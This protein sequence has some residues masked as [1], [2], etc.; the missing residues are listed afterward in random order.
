MKRYRQKHFA[1]GWLASFLV[2]L[3][4]LSGITMPVAAQTK[5]IRNDAKQVV[6]AKS[7]YGKGHRS[8]GITKETGGSTGST[9]SA[10]KSTTYPESYNL[11]DMGMVT[12]V[13][14]QGDYGT[15]WAFAATAAMESN[16]LMQGLGEYDLSE[17]QLAY[18]EFNN[19]SV[20]A[21]GLEGDNVTLETG[22]WYEVG[23]NNVLTA[24]LLAKGYGPVSEQDVPY[25]R[26]TSKLSD[27]YA[28]SSNALDLD[29]V[30]EIASNNKNAIKEAIM[31]NGAVTMSAYMEKDREYYNSATASLYVGRRE[32]ADH[33]V[34][35]VGWDDNYSRENF[36]RVKPSSNGAWLCKNSWGSSWGK[37]GY[38][39][40]SYEDVVSNSKS[41]SCYSFVMK[42][43]GTYSNLYQYDG[44]GSIA[45]YSGDGAANIF[46]ARDKEKITAIRVMNYY[47]NE[48][49]T[50]TI[51][52]GVEDGKPES[53]T[54]VLTQKVTFGQSGYETIELK[55]PVVVNS[56]QTF[57]V[58]VTYANTTKICVDEDIDY[59]WI[60]YDVN[61]EDGQSFIKSSSS[62]NWQSTGPSS[63]YI[64]EPCNVRVKALAEP[65][66]GTE[67]LELTA[68]TVKAVNSGSGRVKLTWSSVVDA[69]G[70]YVYRKA[71]DGEYK[72]L[73]DVS[74]DETTYVNSGLVIGKQYSYYVLPYAEGYTAEASTE[75]VIK[76]ILKAP[77]NLA[78]SNTT[79]RVTVSWTKSARA[80]KY[81]IYRREK[82]GSYSLIAVTGNTSSYTDRSATKGKTYYYK[83]KAVAGNGKTS[84]YSAARGIK[85][86]K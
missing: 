85:V 28:Y 47:D 74:A 23:G 60:A 61:V 70:Y 67:V 45:T 16:A 57:S 31:K 53:G 86:T 26:I 7:G 38:F 13:K 12:S 72:L 39:W 50:I 54:K 65:L 4:L 82:S 10:R 35:V 8:L 59:G 37:N 55:T 46:T 52:K 71:G 76:T 80:V 58:C 83:I 68:P 14:D 25:S 32:Q 69:E 84:A 49:A 29:S 3:M 2:V 36:G 33:E 64:S 48:S 20:Q 11:V 66:D 27:T 43:S 42:K 81:Q 5:D 18:F 40:I 44:G 19:P 78:L 73:A 15:C 63:K 62:G 30:Y 41:E 56:G 24:T 22:T 9:L 6:T 34:C 75:A 51:Y 77:T 21:T 79:G 17:A 1:S